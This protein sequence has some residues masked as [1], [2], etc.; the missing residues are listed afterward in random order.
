MKFYHLR[1]EDRQ[2]I[3]SLVYATGIILFWRGIWEASY[4]IPL[5]ENVYFTLFVGLFILTVTGYLYR[6]FDPLSQKLHRIGRLLHE[7]V[8]MSKKGKKHDI[9][10][11]TEAGKDKH[12]FSA[13]KASKIEHDFIITKEDGHEKFIPIRRITQ[14]RK[15][16]NIIWKR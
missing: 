4:D 7:V 2:F 6:E 13:H 11:Y 10:N 1:E 8:N 12:K 5:L 3:Y 9:H 14:I 15:G 16:K